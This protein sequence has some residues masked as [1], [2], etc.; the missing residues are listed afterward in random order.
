MAEMSDLELLD[1]L[2]VEAEPR[3]KAV[4]SK[5]EQRIIAGFEDIQHFVEQHG[6]SP[7]HGED[8]DIF[9]RLYAVRLEQIARLATLPPATLNPENIRLRKQLGF[10]DR[11]LAQK[12]NRTES[13]FRRWR[14]FL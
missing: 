6:R 4:H 3:K 7:A 12:L 13:E 11:Q 2:G 9:E 10:S 8:K 1:A 5:R 14:C